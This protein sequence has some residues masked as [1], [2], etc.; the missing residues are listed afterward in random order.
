[1]NRW[2]LAELV[3]EFQV[4]GDERNV[5]HVDSV[6]VQADTR[7][8]AWH[9]AVELGRAAEHAYENTE[10]R[11]VRKSFRG[12]RQLMVL[13]EGLEHGSELFYSEHVDVPEERIREW[14]GPREDLAA[15]LVAPD[16]S[17]GEPNL[18]P[19]DM[20]RILLSRSAPASEG[21]GTT[22]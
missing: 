14:T 8:H 19:G 21:S 20:A 15:F 22:G 7:V 10:G 6:L 3:M 12:L 9:A 1:M 18:M 4:E 5:V 11:R 13:W 2:F 16:P 17:D